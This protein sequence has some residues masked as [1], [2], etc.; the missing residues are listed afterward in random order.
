MNWLLCVVLSLPKGGMVL[1]FLVLALPGLVM[2]TEGPQVTLSKSVQ[3]TTVAAGGYVTYTITLTNSGNAAAEG[4]TVRDTLPAGFA[5]RSGT[6]RVSL[7]GATVSTAN[8]AVSGRTLTWSGF[9]L[10]S[11]RSDSFYGVHTFVQRRS[12][13]GYIDYQL[14]RSTELMGNGAYV[15]QL[16]D[17]IGTDWQ[18][19]QNWMRDFVNKAYDRALTPVVRLAGGRGTY[20][21]KPKPDADGSYTTWAQAFKRVVQGLPRRDGRWLYVQIWNEP[22]LNGEWEGQANPSEYGRFLVDTAAAIRSIGDPRIVILNAPLSP[23]GEYYQLDYLEDML[24]SI[25]ATL[26]AFDVWASH[27]YPNNHPPEYNIHNGTARY[28]DATIDLYQQE[29]EILARHGRSGV[30]VLLT[31]TGYALYQADFYFE[32][33]PAINEANRADYIMR[34]F[35]DYWSRWPEVIGVCPFELVDPE[36][37]WWVWDWLWNDGRSHQQYDTVKAL[38]KSYSPVS[39]VLRI[40]FQAEAASTAGTYYNDV[41][42]TANNATIPS[43]THVAPVTVY[44][45][46]PTR[47]STPTRT[48]TPTTSPTTTPTTTETWTPTS[49]ITLT[50]EDT[51]TPT[52]SATPA[53]SLTA[54][55]F[56]TPTISETPTPTGTPTSYTPTDTPTP[57]WTPTLMPS[58][59]RTQTP[60]VTTTPLPTPTTTVTPS[61]TPGCSDLIANGGFETTE[62]WQI[63]SSAYPAAY[64]TARAHS[65]QRSMRLGIESGNNV[66]SYSTVAQRITIPAD[67]SDIRLSCWYYSQSTD[68]NG[69]FG[70]I[71]VYHDSLNAELQRLRTIRE[72]SQTWTHCEYVLNAFR[73]MTVRVLFGTYNDGQ[74]GLTAMYVDD[75]AVPVCGLTPTP[76]ASATLSPTPT[77][78]PTRTL[79][80]TY[81]P[82]PSPTATWTATASPTNTPTKTVLPTPSPSLT[83]T[84]TPSPTPGCSDLVVD[85]G[86]EW[87]DEAWHIPPT[88]YSAGYTTTYAHSGQRSMRLGIASGSNVY[89]YSTVWQAIHVPA[90]AQDAVLTFWYYLVSG[91]TVGD[92]QYALIQDEHGLILNW[93]LS[94]RSNAQTWTLKEYSLAAYKG[95]DIRISFGVYNDGGSGTTAM[96]VDDVSAPICGLT[97]TPSA[98]AGVSS[99]RVFLPVILRPSGEEGELHGAVSAEPTLVSDFRPGVHT[100]WKA[101][102]PD[103]APDLIQGVALNPSNDLLYMAAGK[104]IWVLDAGTGKTIAYIP[105]DTAPRGLAV[106][107]AANRVYAALWEVDA[108]A[109]IDGAQQTLWKVVPGIPGAS[110]VAVGD[111]Y[112]Y[113]TAT[114][115][116]ELIIVDRP[117]C[118]II[119]RVAIGNA[120]YAVAYDPGR[121]R[122]YVGNAGEDTVSI[123]DGHNGALVNTVKLGGLGHPQGLALDSIRDRLYVTYALSPKYRAV[124]VIDA[125]SGQILSRLVGNEKRSLL[126]A[127]GIAV[128][129]LR[130]WVYVTT[131]DEVLALAGET[132]RVVKVTSGA[133]PAYAFGLCV[134]PVEER[135]YI[136]DGQHRRLAVCSN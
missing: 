35:R 22:N 33:Y 123:V 54:T 61:P 133:G 5:Y 132:L 66:R 74:N 104:A 42:A 57:T 29:L 134:S 130:G 131:V 106:D 102:E 28:P 67:A 117:N 10:P 92:L 85:G 108:L 99:A 126:G 112:V 8:P 7:N 58:P 17:W 37:Q 23:G 20:W 122:V 125:C 72:N 120:P 75:V 96:Y 30:K 12:E 26:W 34:A 121:Q 56:L 62:V 14:T 100:L 93:A 135:L 70:Y 90:N 32:G 114:H 44:L 9:K 86:F 69:D 25:P 52:P 13:S 51:Q 78:T 47:T 94:V 76:I 15:T 79:T 119:N 40:T 71:S 27:P 101:P 43:A 88:A 64:T 4:I 65:G 3:P 18:G 105:L 91:D 116:D 107:V 68:T 73:G 38:D 109:V 136:A 39:S 128:D 118:A 48:R 36:E 16:F 124:A 115:G 46:T 50:P 81:T 19:P 24:T 103:A 95:E 80:R 63:S 11:S 97:P 87:D 1:L 21:I 45:P 110:G 113:V 41:S 6:T 77:A 49:T 84:L 60:T 98:T 89:S 2:A 111:D 55:A 82:S 127:Y 83:M 53:A 59:T 129:P 31:E